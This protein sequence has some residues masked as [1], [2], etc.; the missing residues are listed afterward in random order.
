MTFTVTRSQPRCTAMGDF[1]LMCWTALSTT[2]TTT[3]TTAT[4]TTPFLRNSRT[5]FR[6]RSHMLNV[7]MNR[8]ADPKNSEKLWK[9]DYCLSLDT[10]SHIVWCPAFASLREGKNLHDENDLID[11][12]NSVMKARDNDKS[13]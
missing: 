9:C 13:D 12:V 2:I 6:L 5:K 11:Y 7:K 10:Q 3:I 8:K 4:T 1:G